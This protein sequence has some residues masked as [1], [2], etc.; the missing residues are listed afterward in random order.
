MF[1]GK[2]LQHLGGQTPSLWPHEQH[3]SGLKSDLIG[4]ASTLGRAGKDPSARQGSQGISQSGMTLYFSP[5]VI[6]QPRP[7]QA[8]VVQFKAQGLNQMQPGAAIGTKAYDVAG[9]RRYLRLI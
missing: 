1:G 9:I 3:I 8:L 6:I 4:T 7:T 2:L 5:F